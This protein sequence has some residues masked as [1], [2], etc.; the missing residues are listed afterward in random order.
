MKRLIGWLHLWLGLASGLVVIV[1]ALSGSLL[2]FEDEL[3]H[4]FEPSLFSVQAPAGAERMSL[5]ALAA[6]IRDTYPKNKLNNIEI[7]PAANSTV[8]FYLK[9][10][11]AK[12][13][14]LMVV[15]DPYTGKIIYSGEQQ[16]RFFVVVKNLHRYL[17][18]GETGKMITGISC[19][20]FTLLIISGLILWWPKKNA[21]KQRMKVKWNASFKRLNWDLHAVFGFYIHVV[22]FIT[23]ITGLIWSYKWVNNLLFYAFD[24]KPQSKVE[25]PVS[26]AEKIND[27]AWL[28]KIFAA[29][30][31]RLTYNGIVNIR[32]PEKKDQAITVGKENTDRI[33][34]HIVDV[35]YFQPG[36]GTFVG[37]KLFANDTRGTQARRLVYPIHTGGL[38][39]WPT[40][41]LAF[42]CALVAASLPV[43]GFLIW[44]GKKHKKP[45][46]KKQ[47][48]QKSVVA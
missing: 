19:S 30:N 23:A 47:T 46:V 45:I 28:D 33:T 39:G 34:T 9:K 7:Q 5:D 20:I 14:L 37:D 6:T 40:K 2:V 18:M 17:C 8:T 38:F 27:V 26:K 24:G 21:R 29:T 42:I 16:K 35:L 32:F 15:M 22:I 36:S 12:G 44:W 13:D 1:V 43:T 41:I 31:Q 10:G 25:A 4:L 11:K 3:E 48:R